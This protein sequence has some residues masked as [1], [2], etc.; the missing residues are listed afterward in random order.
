M[1]NILYIAYILYIL[2][3]IILTITKT[4]AEI[5]RQKIG[6]LSKNTRIYTGK[7]NS[8]TLKK[9]VHVQISEKNYRVSFLK[10]PNI[11]C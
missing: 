3:N 9:R 11:F 4:I 7:Q 5:C 2:N 1:V 6:F 8:K 10:V